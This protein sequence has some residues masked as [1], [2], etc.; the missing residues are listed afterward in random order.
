MVTME[1]IKKREG[2]D[3]H[4]FCMQSRH[5]VKTVPKK[6]TKPVPPAIDDERFDAIRK[7]A[8]LFFTSLGT[9]WTADVDWLVFA[10]I[11]SATSLE[12]ANQLGADAKEMLAV[13]NKSVPNN[14]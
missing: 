5:K 14:K 6:R 1:E 4:K 3:L 9:N 7:F 12:N 2:S 11:A 10:D 8:Q 13:L